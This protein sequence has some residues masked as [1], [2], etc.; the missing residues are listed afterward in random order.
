[1][2]QSYQ[3]HCDCGSVQLSMTGTPRVHAYCHC[4]DCRELLDVPYHSIV[5]WDGDDV[6]VTAGAEHSSVYPHPTL[7]MTRVF[8]KNCGENPVQH[9]CHGLENW[10]RNCSSASV[11]AVNCRR[12]SNPTRI[13]STIGVSSISPIESP[14]PDHP[15]T[16]TV[17]TEQTARL[18]V[19]LVS[20]I[21]CPW[22]VVGYLRLQQAARNLDFGLDIEWHPFELNPNMA[23]DG[24]DL[25]QHFHNKYGMTREST[26]QLGQTLNDHGQPLGF[27]FNYPAG[28]RIRNT[29]SAHQ[30]LAWAKPQGADTA[31]NEALFEAY[32]TDQRD[33][34]SPEVLLE[35]ARGDRAGPGRGRSGAVTGRLRRTGAKRRAGM[36]VPGNPCR[37]G[38][39]SGQSF[40]AERG[41]LGRRIRTTDQP[42]HERASSRYSLIKCRTKLPSRRPAGRPATSRIRLHPRTM[43]GAC[44]CYSRTLRWTTPR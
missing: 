13:F 44:W 40:P 22:C 25:Y 12:S 38:L 9:Q 6:S 15:G 7:E 34:A 10:C 17:Q 31:L 14:N 26:D 3:V 33:I 23:E 16:R 2:S 29:F 43:R 39:D 28:N 11:T 21:V 36:V 20:D 18:K 1:M 37:S 5:A 30:L 8:C 4:E 35:V 32:F 19:D 42:Q 24:E 41:A 27:E